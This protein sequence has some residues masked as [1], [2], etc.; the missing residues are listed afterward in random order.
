[1]VHLKSKQKSKVAIGAYASTLSFMKYYV[2]EFYRADA[3]FF[4]IFG[5]GKLFSSI[6]IEW[7]EVELLNEGPIKDPELGYVFK[8]KGFLPS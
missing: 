2:V 7:E 4:S 3:E 8:K 6:N 5:T 1:M